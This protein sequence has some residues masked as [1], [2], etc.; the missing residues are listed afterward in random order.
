MWAPDH[1]LGNGNELV[2]N[3]PERRDLALQDFGD[4]AG[5]VRP[6]SE[7]GHLFT[8]DAQHGLDV[9]PL[10]LGC[11]PAPRAQV[12]APERRWAL[13]YAP[14]R[15]LPRVRNSALSA[16]ERPG[17]SRGRL[18]RRGEAGG[19]RTVSAQRQGLLHLIALQQPPGHSLANHHVAGVEPTG[20]E[21][22]GS[23]HAPRRTPRARQTAAPNC[24]LGAVLRQTVPRHQCPKTFGIRGRPTLR[25][26][27]RRGGTV[28]GRLTPLQRARQPVLP[29]S[30]SRSPWPVAGPECVACQV[31]RF[32]CSLRSGVRNRG[33]ASNPP[34]WI[35]RGS[36]GGTAVAHWSSQRVEPMTVESQRPTKRPTLASLSAIATVD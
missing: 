6:W 21:A 11:G 32:F 10:L 4:V 23:L 2:A 17:D 27:V 28:S 18:L 24:G 5:P 20:G 30:R 9:S 29:A 33:P 19:S 22:T 25:S 15:K 8:A 16:A 34:V 7:L 31:R 1:S 14:R 26:F 13:E 3:G 35:H 36:R 12:K